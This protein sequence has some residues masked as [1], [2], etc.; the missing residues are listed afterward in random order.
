LN[1]A[2]F[3]EDFLRDVLDQDYPQ[4]RVEI[5]IADGGSSD[6]TREKLAALSAVET[7]VRVIDNPD[8]FQAPGLNRIIR[9]ARGDLIIRMDVHCRYAS[10][11]LRRCVELLGRTGADN[12]GGAARVVARTFFQRAVAAAYDSPLGGGGAPFRSAANE[13]YVDTVFPGA[14]RR[15]VFETV[16]LFDPAAQVNEDA[17]LNQRILQSGGRIYLSREIDVHH[18]PRASLSA[19]AL[20]YF[21][22]G[23]GR[24]RTLVKHRRLPVWRPVIPFAML[25]LGTVVVAVPIL[26][27]ILPWAVA[28]YAGLVLLESVRAGRD[29]GLRNILLLTLVFPVLHAFHGAGFGAGLVRYLF[30][31]DWAPPERLPPR[32]S[33][34]S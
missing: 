21:R 32:S 30:Q 29:A 31:P 34:T 4:E 13:G 16:G 8:R 11:F 19:L 25:S 24:A 27:P 2:H 26:R 7:R 10:D 3:L 12:V 14:F 28:T 1:E 23:Q 5:V 6:G 22:Y 9:E 17:E 18:Y 33:R 20:Q 15:R